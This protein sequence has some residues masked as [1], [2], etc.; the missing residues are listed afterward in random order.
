MYCMSRSDIPNCSK[1]SLTARKRIFFS[2]FS[3]KMLKKT[4]FLTFKAYI[5]LVF[6][7]ISMKFSALL[8]KRCIKNLKLLKSEKK[9]SVA[10]NGGSW[11]P[12]EK[13]ARRRSNC[14]SNG[15]ECPIWTWNTSKSSWDLYVS[16][17]ILLSL[18]QLL[19]R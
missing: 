11:Q 13:F 18:V 8:D 6:Q 15:S 1:S 2:F 4:R 5:S 14:S 19:Q 7:W 10:Q 3:R 17:G 9:Y 12:T 16:K